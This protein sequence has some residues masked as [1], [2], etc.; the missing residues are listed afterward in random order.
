MIKKENT[1][2]RY[3]MEHGT[4]ET[5]NIFDELMKTEV[6]VTLFCMT[7]FYTG[8]IEAVNCETLVLKGCEQ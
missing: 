4:E 3:G 7:Y 1:I 6:Q 5:T 8:V 2:R